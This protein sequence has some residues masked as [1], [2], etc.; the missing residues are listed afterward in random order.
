MPPDRLVVFSLDDRRF[1]LR[2]H[3]VERVVRAA[4]IDLLPRAPAIVLGVVNLGG[5]IIPV[6]DPRR[7][8]GAPGR[9]LTPEDHLIV[10]RAGGR[11]VALLVD[12][13]QDVVESHAAEVT[14][15]TEILPGLPYVEGVAKLSDGLIFIHDLDTFLSLD[16]ARALDQ[17]LAAAGASR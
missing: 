15:A 4:A 13:V 9:A 3:V 6:T 14:P 17:A 11:E 7:R 1:A 16:E 10:A 12:A 8:F 2:L 5:R